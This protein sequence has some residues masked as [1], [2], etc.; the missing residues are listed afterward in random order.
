KGL[1]KSAI[2]DPDPVIFM[3]SEVMY[4][5]K[6][7]V[8]EEEYYLPI[9]KANTIQEGTDVTIVSFGKMIPRVV[10]PAVA[11]LEKEGISVELIDLRSGRRI[12]Y[13]AILESVKKTNRLVVVEEAL[14]LASISS[15]IAFHV[16]KN[17]FDYL[18]AT[19]TRVTS[20]D[21]PLAYAPTLVEASLPSIEKVVK[22]VKEVSYLKK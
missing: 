16:Q 22:A 4:G 7:P 14:P 11:A 9:G 8:P 1:L 18:D 2:I 17:A 13:T 10:I 19:V 3:E 21:V 6:G 12:C 5:D 15:E 20:A